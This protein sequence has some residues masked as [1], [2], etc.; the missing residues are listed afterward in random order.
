VEIFELITM[1]VLITD[2]K[3]PAR[4]AKEIESS[5]GCSA[6]DLV[7]VGMAIISSDHSYSTL[8]CV[9]FANILPTFSRLVIDTLLILYME[10][11]MAFLL[12]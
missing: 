6:S 5:F 11:G 10:I 2:A 4:A 9:Q 7:L 8:K 12:Y 3:K 1:P